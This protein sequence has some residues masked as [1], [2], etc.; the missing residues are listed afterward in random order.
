MVMSDG[1]LRGRGGVRVVVVV[2]V[3]MATS[4]GV[5]GSVGMLHSIQR[6]T[7]AGRAAAARSAHAID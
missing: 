1:E 4:A 2:I 6:P 3:V 7:K 5:R